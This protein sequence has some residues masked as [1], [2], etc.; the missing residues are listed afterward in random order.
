M[1]I[2]RTT[3]RLQ[4]LV[5]AI[6]LIGFVGCKKND[7]GPAPIKE[8]AKSSAK[9]ISG[10]EFSVPDAMG[11][12]MTFTGIIDDTA[13]TIAATLP[14]NTDQTALAPEIRVSEKAGISPTGA[15]DFTDPIAYT[16][17]AEDGSTAIYTITIT[18]A[19]TQKQILQ[20]ILDAN[21]N[22]TL[23]WD[24]ENTTADQL[25][26]L[27]GVHTNLEG[28]IYKLVLSDNALDQ[29]PSEIGQLTSLKE[30][31]LTDNQFTGLP[32]GFS[33]LSNLEKLYMEYNEFMRFPSEVFSLSKLEHLQIS[34]NQIT[35]LL[36]EI[37]QLT[38]LVTLTL[39]SNQLTSLPSEI[40]QLSA[41]NQLYAP[42]NNIGSLP[43]ELY[44]LTGLRE[45]NLGENQIT[46]ILSEIGQLTNLEQLDL[47][48]NLLTSI[49]PE[50]GKLI[51]LGYLALSKNTI[52]SLPPEMG[53]LTNLNELQMADNDITTMPKAICNLSDFHGPMTFEMDNSTT[54]GIV[55]ETDV[56][57]SLYNSN[58]G[59]T[60]EWG[61]DNYHDVEFKDNGKV[62]IITLNN[63]GLTAIPSYIDQLTE[64]ESLNMNSNPLGDSGLP[65]SIGN[66]STLLGLTLGSTNITTVPSEFG[67][68]S[69]LVLLSL[70]NNPITS[71][72]QSVC[73]L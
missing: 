1:S 34:N 25:N 70:T 14:S 18:I 43:A 48:N 66:I 63:K 60:I 55:S 28:A 26:T 42:S 72:P 41:L 21:P 38:S 8:V 62:R 20:A 24:L 2:R 32:S 64:L 39:S 5:M 45:I 67:Q 7:A 10:F 57:V 49:P 12:M 22:N 47:Y 4:L 69:N 13:K 59:N 68:L 16:V 31:Y 6:A 61:V 71:I 50:I 51:N 15:Q 11:T 58:V 29:L 53:F 27:N 65:A 9:E 73:N 37:G 52:T 3:R 30:L 44:Q 46:T 35:T 40:G 36:S 33:Q 56:L 17:T 54:C 23:G 19:L